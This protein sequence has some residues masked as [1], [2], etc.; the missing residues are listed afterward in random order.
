M[1][2][3]YFTSE[4]EIRC[5]ILNVFI[6][7]GVMVWDCRAEAGKCSDPIWRDNISFA[8]KYG[9]IPFFWNER[10]YMIELKF[11]K[12]R[13]LYDE[14]NGVYRLAIFSS[15]IDDTQSE[16]VLNGGG[17]LVVVAEPSTEE[18]GVPPIWKVLEDEC[19]MESERLLW[20]ELANG[21]YPYDI[22]ILN[23][24]QFS[25]FWLES[26]LKKKRKFKRKTTIRRV[27][28]KSDLLKYASESR[29]QLTLQHI[30]GG[31]I[32]K[33]ILKALE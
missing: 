12:H 14:E 31:E 15:N 33:L 6:K 25:Q 3:P 20:S 4:E 22:F 17:L 8:L 32:G 23:Q 21:K 28:D 1:D 2:L 13:C 24:K 29:T 18:I 27:L 10:F 16:I 11:I 9:D 5:F 19:E 7:L 30:T 26:L